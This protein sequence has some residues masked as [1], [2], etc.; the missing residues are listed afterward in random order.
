MREGSTQGT[1]HP[2]E[3]TMLYCSEVLH[4]L[5]QMWCF[6]AYTGMVERENTRLQCMVGERPVHILNSNKL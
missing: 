2:Q 4:I 3:E 5:E 1:P 6:G